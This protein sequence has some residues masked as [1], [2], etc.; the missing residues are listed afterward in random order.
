MM[1]GPTKPG[2]RRGFDLIGLV[3]RVRLAR[4]VCADAVGAYDGQDVEDG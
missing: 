2:S 3:I 4:H 1:R